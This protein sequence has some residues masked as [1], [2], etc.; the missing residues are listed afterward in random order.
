MAQ[1]LP[2]AV[3]NPIFQLSCAWEMY[4]SFLESESGEDIS[5]TNFY[6]RIISYGEPGLSLTMKEGVA[7]LKLD[8]TA[9]PLGELQSI[10]REG[11]HPALTPKKFRKAFRDVTRFRVET[12]NG[13]RRPILKADA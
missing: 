2:E 9:A 3:F 1:Q 7:P 12:E 4:L 13:K 10:Y 5:F 8:M 6:H 11:G